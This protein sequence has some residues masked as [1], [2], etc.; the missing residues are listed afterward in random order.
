MADDLLSCILEEIRERKEAARGGIR[1]S[2][3]S[4]R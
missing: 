3:R 4:A 1:V 2:E